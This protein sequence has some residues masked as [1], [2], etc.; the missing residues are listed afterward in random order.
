MAHKKSP[1][2]CSKTSQVIKEKR[3]CENE[4]FSRNGK[5]RLFLLVFIIASSLFKS[6][7]ILC[8]FS[9]LCY[10]TFD[11][12]N[13][14]R[15][16]NSLDLTP[17]HELTRMGKVF[18]FFIFSLFSFLTLYFSSFVFGT[19]FPSSSCLACVL[20]ISERTSITK[21]NW[22][23]RF[24]KCVLF[25]S[26]QF[27][28][29]LC[30]IKRVCVHRAQEEDKQVF[31]WNLFFKERIS[32]CFFFFSSSDQLYAEK[33]MQTNFCV[34]E[35]LFE[36][37]RYNNGHIFLRNDL[38]LLRSQEKKLFRLNNTLIMIVFRRNFV[39]TKVVLFCFQ[40]NVHKKFFFLVTFTS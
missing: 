26:C 13:W 29:T 28:F 25:T 30:L 7:R 24:L 35:F 34:R 6:V 32:I 15:K 20:L 17:T 2:M 8:F 37:M 21:D 38:A 31:S 19:F 10:I 27:P 5:Y 9:L 16:S 36:T 4:P 40:I 18:V 11:G 1:K 14:P 23:I 33:C 12:N 22:W 39:T 3:D